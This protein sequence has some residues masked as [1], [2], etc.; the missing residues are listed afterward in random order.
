MKLDIDLRSGR[1]SG[2]WA[3]TPSISW[4][5]RSDRVFA[6]HT[7]R[8]SCRNRAVLKSSNRTR[9][10]SKGTERNGTDM[11][12]E[13]IVA[14]AEM[15]IRSPV[16]K[17]FDAFVEPAITSKFWFSRGSAKLEAGKSVRWD[18]DMYG[19]S[20]EAKVKELEP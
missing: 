18:W 10:K 16:S 19:F 5:S 14:K 8:S 20:T 2:H 7:P 12:G 9:R 6:D 11:A 4:Y 1:E 15:L 17:V 13:R 3:G